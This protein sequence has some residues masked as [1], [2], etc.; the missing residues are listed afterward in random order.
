MQ[1]AR[2]SRQQIQPPELLPNCWRQSMPESQ[3]KPRCTISPGILSTAA[4]LSRLVIP[5]STWPV[6]TN[7]GA[8]QNCN[9]PRVSHLPTCQPL[10]K[11]AGRQQ[12]SMAGY[13]LDSQPHYPPTFSGAQTIVIFGRREPSRSPAQPFTD[14][15]SIIMILTHITMILSHIQR[16]IGGG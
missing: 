2:C 11:G 9:T 8:P 10:T 6:Y 3:P 12:R 5:V 4:T 15:R 16:W 13:A 7:Y 14:P 1:L